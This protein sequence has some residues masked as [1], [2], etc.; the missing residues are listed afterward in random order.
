MA[1]L[2]EH[3]WSVIELQIW[4]IW[5]FKKEDPHCNPK[6]F[7]EQQKMIFFLNLLANV[8]SSFIEIFIRKVGWRSRVSFPAVLSE[9]LRAEKTKKTETMTKSTDCVFCG[10]KGW[11]TAENNECHSNSSINVFVIEETCHRKL[12]IREILNGSVPCFV[13]FQCFL[14][15]KTFFFSYPPRSSG[16][17][18]PNLC[19]SPL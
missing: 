13:V 10:V 8:I 7:I 18:R 1:K 16:Q 11:A 6:F 4:L 15:F 9:Y 17:K 14:F 19:T 5:K 3:R 12:E 2:W